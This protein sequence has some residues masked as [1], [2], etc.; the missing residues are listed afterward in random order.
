MP[1]RASCAAGCSCASRLCG[2]AQTAHSM[3][4]F[5]SAAIPCRAPAGLIRKGCD[6]RHRERRRVHESGHPWPASKEAVALRPESIEP[7]ARQLSGGSAGMHGFVHERAVRGAEHRRRGG[8][9]P[10]GRGEGSPRSRSSTGCTVCATP[11]RREAQG[12]SIRTMRIEPPRWALAFL[13]TFWA[14]PK[15]NS[16]A[17]RASES[18]ALEREKRIARNWIPACAGMTSEEIP[19]PPDPPP[20]GRAKDGFRRAPE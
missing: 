10:K 2:V 11:P 9:S 5:A 13:V 14:M 20:E 16:L 18:S 15:S 3:C 8:K 4:R 6:A 12:S 7:R 17:R 1:R 19:S